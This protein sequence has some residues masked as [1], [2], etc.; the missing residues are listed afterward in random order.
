VDVLFSHVRGEQNGGGRSVT[1]DSA[2]PAADRDPIL[3]A[4]LGM[5][6]GKT[7]TLV[8]DE[9]DRY[10]DVRGLSSMASDTATQPS[11]MSI[12]ESKD[13]ANLF[14]KS[15]E[16]GLP[17]VPVSVGDTWTADETIQFPSAGEVRVQLNG[18]LQS[19]EPRNGHQH[20]KVMFDGKMGNTA[21]REGKPVGMTE[22]TSDSSLAG[23][24]L[25][26]LEEKVVSYA[27]YTTSVRM[28][29]PGGMVVFDQKISS[30]ITS[31]EA[32]PA[33]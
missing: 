16:M 31:I 22:I 27:A 30:K 32:T 25:Y 11:M 29:T 10:R 21:P 9:Q 26:D 6:V 14:R 4:T 3:A 2:T 33:K 7:F 18:K 19:I 24:L 8:F 15:L 1:F 17:P 20:A 13:V 5:A 28:Q 12:A 23:I